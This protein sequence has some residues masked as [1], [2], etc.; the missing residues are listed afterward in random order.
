MTNRAAVLMRPGEIAMQQRP[1]PTPAPREVLVEVTSVGVFGI[2]CR[3]RGL[4]NAH[5]T[6]EVAGTG[7]SGR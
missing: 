3:S 6:A 7:R 2:S 5:F 4:V 1:I